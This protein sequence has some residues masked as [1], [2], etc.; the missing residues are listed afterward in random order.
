MVSHWE[1]EGISLC[2]SIHRKIPSRISFWKK[3]EK[4]AI[5]LAELQN[6]NT[7]LVGIILLR[8]K[9]H[10]QFCTKFTDIETHDCSIQATY[11]KGWSFNSLYEDYG[12]NSQSAVINYWYSWLHIMEQK[13]A[14]LCNHNEQKL[15]GIRLLNNWKLIFTLW[16]I[17]CLNRWAWWGSDKNLR[18]SQVQTWWI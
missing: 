12:Y 16:F 15:Q 4:K 10:P 6:H 11:C 9:V 3:K 8:I 2:M 5:L 14:T 13:S 17:L 1:I 7:L 18:V